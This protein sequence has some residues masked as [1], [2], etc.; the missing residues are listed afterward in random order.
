MKAKLTVSVIFLLASVLFLGSWGIAQDK[1]V[2]VTS[3]SRWHQNK[4]NVAFMNNRISDAAEQYKEYAPIPRIAFYD[5]GYPKDK[6]EFGELNGYGL[7]LISAISHNEIELPLK[8]VYAVLNNK[9][10]ELKSVKQILTKEGNTE[11]Q[12][13][14]TFG[15]YRADTLYLFPVYL[16]MNRAEILIDFA[17]NRDGMK[18][19]SFNGEMPEI[20][21]DLP[22][23][24]PFVK[25]SF[26]AAIQNFMK[27]EYPGFFETK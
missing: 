10:I 11:S 1:T 25:K 23:T 26:A 4:V 12:V 18:M 14:K 22:N 8:R 21:K 6:V 9:E 5:I 15:L 19:A 17:Q 2:T 7:L 24:K 27:R 20:L 13:V 16:R 3:E